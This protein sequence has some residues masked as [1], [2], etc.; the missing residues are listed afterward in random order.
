MTS[1]IWGEQGNPDLLAI[2]NIANVVNNRGQVAGVSAM[3]GNTATHAFLWT[4]ERGKMLDLGTLPGDV[5]SAA[6]GINDRGEMVGASFGAA[7]PING[8][9]R[10]FLWK[11]GGMTDLNDLIPA[12]FAITSSHCLWYQ[13]CWRDRRLWRDEQR[14]SSRFPCDSL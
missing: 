14:R 11:D 5:N 10:A 13:R 8:N 6:L 2:G 9:P 3:S 4:R 12:E 1:A 7:G